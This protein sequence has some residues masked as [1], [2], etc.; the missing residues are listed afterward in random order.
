MG[1]PLLRFQLCV[2]HRLLDRS[3]SDIPFGQRRSGGMPT[4]IGRQ[5]P[6][7]QLCQLRIVPGIVVVFLD[8]N[9]LAF[10]PGMEDQIVDNRRKEMRVGDGGLSAHG[11]L[12]ADI[13]DLHRLPVHVADIEP[14]H[15]ARHHAGIDHQQDRPG[16]R[17]TGGLCRPHLVQLRFNERLSLFLVVFRQNQEP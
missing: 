1:V 13:G 12:Q 8:G 11:G 17:V 7:A 4:G 15:L 2:A 16:D 14:Q 10:L 5:L 3:G 9:H 6:D